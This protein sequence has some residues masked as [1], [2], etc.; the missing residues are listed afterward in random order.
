[1]NEA[2]KSQ[3]SAVPKSE[4]IARRRGEVAALGRLVRAFEANPNDALAIALAQYA[5]ARKA[6]KKAHV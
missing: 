4:T 6:L 2:I 1:M 5:K 3:N